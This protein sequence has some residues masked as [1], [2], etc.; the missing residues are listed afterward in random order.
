MYNATFS[1]CGWGGWGGVGV[2][3]FIELAHMLDATELGLIGRDLSASTFLSDY[4]QYSS[5][6]QCISL[7]T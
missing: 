3:A 6:R 2:I 4:S 1:W 5:S 7:G